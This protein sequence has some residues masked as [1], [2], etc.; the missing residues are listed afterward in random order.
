M[1][2]G[3]VFA[4]VDGKPDSNAAPIGA[5]TS[6]TVSPMRSSTPVAFAMVKYALGEPNTK[7]YVAAEGRMVEATVQAGLAFWKRS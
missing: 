5:I 6:S 1:T 4:P 7:L 3:P 2:G